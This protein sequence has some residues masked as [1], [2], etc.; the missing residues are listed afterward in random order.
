[1]KDGKRG[2]INHP[3]DNLWPKAMF[4]RALMLCQKVAKHIPFM[5]I[6]CYLGL[7]SLRIFFFFRFI[8][9]HYR[10]PQHMSG[11][12]SSGL[13]FSFVLICPHYISVDYD[14]FHLRSYQNTTTQCNSGLV[15]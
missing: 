2:V 11:R 4:L 10:A 9:F 15:V 12:H 13:L 3:T 7:N 1:M 14:T 5:N 6:L 8:T